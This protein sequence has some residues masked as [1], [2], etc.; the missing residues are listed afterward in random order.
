MLACSPVDCPIPHPTGI[1][2]YH[3]MPQALKRMRNFLLY[4]PLTIT[5]CSVAH[6]ADPAVP[7]LDIEPQTL[8]APILSSPDSGQGIAQDDAGLGIGVG[9][10]SAQPPAAGG[11]K[12]EF[13]GTQVMPG[14]EAF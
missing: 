2:R 6:A 7:M 5:L 14:L 12:D 8:Q 9:Q 10:P 13:G 3:Y 1:I 11:L 4:L